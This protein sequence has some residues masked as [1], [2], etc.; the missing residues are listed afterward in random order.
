LKQKEHESEVPRKTMLQMPQKNQIT[1][2]KPNQNKTKTEKE[3]FDHV[4]E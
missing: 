4:I 1:K 2:N 3:K